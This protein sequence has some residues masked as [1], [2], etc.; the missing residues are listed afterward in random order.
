[1]SVIKTNVWPTSKSDLIRK[2]YKEFKK[3]INEIPFD[4]LKVA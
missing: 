1:L 4:E 2:Y 3:F